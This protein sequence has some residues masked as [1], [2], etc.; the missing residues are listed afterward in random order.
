M[1]I[2]QSGVG[3]PHSGGSELFHSQVPAKEMYHSDDALFVC[4]DRVNAIL[5]AGDVFRF[6][7]KVQVHSFLKLH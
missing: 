3:D 6:D 2:F 4:L 5:K 7:E 1:G